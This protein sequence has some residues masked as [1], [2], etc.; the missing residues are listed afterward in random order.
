MIISK[1]KN[2]K[3]LIK[4]PED[5][6][7]IKAQIN[8]PPG[9]YSSTPKH[10]T[11]APAQGKQL[12][13]TPK[14]FCVEILVNPIALASANATKVI[15][16]AYSVHPDLDFSFKGESVS[17][18][19]EAALHFDADARNKLKSKNNLLLGTGEKSLSEFYRKYYDTSSSLSKKSSKQMSSTLV[20]KSNTTNNGHR[21]DGSIAPDIDDNRT[22]IIKTVTSN[23]RLG[24]LSQKN[25]PILAG[26]VS[27]LATNIRQQGNSRTL[28][29]KRISTTPSRP[30]PNPI[31]HDGVKERLSSTSTGIGRLSSGVKNMKREDARAVMGNIVSGDT[32]PQRFVRVKSN[33]K[34]LSAQIPFTFKL[35]ISDITSQLGN[36]YVEFLVANER[37]AVIERHIRRISTRLVVLPS[38]KKVL[39][40]RVSASRTDIIK[41]QVT[42]TQVDPYANQVL[43]QKSVASAEDYLIGRNKKFTEIERINVLSTDGPVGFTDTGNTVGY[44]TYRAF[45][46]TSQGNRSNDLS[47][48]T[49][50]PNT[51]TTDTVVKVRDISRTVLANIRVIEPMRNDG[52]VI[53]VN[54]RGLVRSISAFYVLSS[55]RGRVTDIND[56]KKYLQNLS[57]DP[58]S[59]VSV[60]NE[61]VFLHPKENIKSGQVYEYFVEAVLENGTTQVVKPS[62]KHEYR[63]LTKEAGI[64]FDVQETRSNYN[65]TKFSIKASFKRDSID[66]IVASLKDVSAFESF[67]DDVQNNRNRFESLL[68]VSVT[69]TNISANPNETYNF[70]MH[71]VNATFTDNS[72][73]ENLTGI[74]GCTPG[75]KYVYRF[76]LF[77]APFSM[78]LDKVDIEKQDPQTLQIIRDIGSSFEN[79]S[80]K[81]RSTLLPPRERLGNTEKGVDE[82]FKS[83]STGKVSSI[84]INM[85]EENCRTEELRVDNDSDS[86]QLSWRVTGNKSRI[87]SFLVL[88]DYNGI[89]A[90]IAN[91]ANSSLGS[92]RVDYVDDQ[93]SQNVGTKIYT[94]VP[95]FH[96]LSVG[97]ES[98]PTEVNTFNS[99]SAGE[100]ER[101]EE[102]D[103]LQAGLAVSVGKI[104]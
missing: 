51:S 87:S 84:E 99:L 49:L 79:N 2:R 61:I 10:T 85:P 70:G 12:S 48:I 35:N 59:T 40:P 11:H 80:T 31:P 91:V 77:I 90:P 8:N 36:L 16:N 94:V 21:G 32:S 34:F 6:F 39:A 86:A 100:E 101:K 95:V 1:S 53:S 72:A 76:E 74:P 97:D 102:P 28:N 22:S 71:D 29:L 83:N 26:P 103:K 46:V 45:A 92:A 69:R 20:L 9:N 81:E 42:V 98:A 7:L 50:P 15:A 104:A 18:F 52:S 5:F 44:V 62:I 19:N 27:I 64:D 4:I 93:M 58:I 23:T 67:L 63:V 56:K 60:S 78:L 24:H 25:V 68:K 66:S 37:N 82:T 47:E 13:I 57:E 43:V 3:N 88:C 55:H 96:D 54:V 73:N 30:L 17:K 89:K 65:G 14:Y 41:T 33:L 38:V 75:S